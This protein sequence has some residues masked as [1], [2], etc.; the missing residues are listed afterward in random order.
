MG[1]VRNALAIGILGF[2]LAW[3]GCGNAGT[4]RERATAG[5]GDGSRES[6]QN[7]SQ[8]LKSPYGQPRVNRAGQA[9][10]G[11]AKHPQAGA[12]Q[13]G[14]A[15]AGGQGGTGQPQGAAR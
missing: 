5:A 14:S 9:M 7:R 13:P 6:A 1:F 15:R 2:G 11:D 10:V 3:A 12:S 4:H 8:D